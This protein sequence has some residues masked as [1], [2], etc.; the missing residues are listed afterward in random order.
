MI[1]KFG[2]IIKNF[3]SYGYR[4]NLN[5]KKQGEIVRTYIGGVISLLVI[6]LNLAFA[7]LKLYIMFSKTNS[8]V[9]S[10]ESTLSLEEF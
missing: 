2:N 3:D 5:F 9:S 6:L 10:L 4:V 8:T 1:K 7:G